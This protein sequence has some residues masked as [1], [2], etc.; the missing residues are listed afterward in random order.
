MRSIDRPHIARPGGFT[1]AET[2]AAVVLLGLAMTM[3]VR[4]LDALAQQRRSAEQ[5]E[6]ALL[7]AANL[8]ER[9]TLREWS[10]LTAERLGAERLSPAAAGRLPAGR[11]KLDVQDLPL[12]ESEPLCRRLEVEI[13]WRGPAGEPRPVR[14]VA[15]VY[16][17]PGGAAARESEP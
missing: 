14:L 5:R 16:R 9:L 4:M 3:T 12:G 6:L 7:E 2:A 8:L 17:T 13:R 1:L 11:L 10:S 15:W